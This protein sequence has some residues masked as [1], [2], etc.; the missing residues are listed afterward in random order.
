MD[1]VSD[2]EPDFVEDEL[3]S[4]IGDDEQLDDDHDDKTFAAEEAHEARESSAAEAVAEALELL[5]HLQ[6]QDFADPDP[7][8][9]ADEPVPAE[10]QDNAAAAAEG[11]EE[12]EAGGVLEQLGLAWA[13]APGIPDVRL[14]VG[15]D[16]EVRYSLTGEYMRAFCPHHKDCVRQRMARERIKDPRGDGNQA[17]EAA[18][19]N[20]EIARGQGR[21]LG[22]LFAWLRAGSDYDTKAAHMKARTADHGTRVAARAALMELPGASDFSADYERPRRAGE[23]EE[24]PKIR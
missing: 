20:T 2:Y 23:E 24:P 8:I 22:A 6:Q 13:R 11:N 16:G 12:P 17:R 9:A 14:S 10:G 19:P 15:R 5:E 3:T 1:D 18:V 21:P 4:E 7:E